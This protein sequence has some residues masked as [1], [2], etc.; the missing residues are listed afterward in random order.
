MSSKLI[1][2][3]VLCVL[4][5]FVVFWSFDMQK[6]DPFNLNGNQSA[7]DNTSRWVTYRNEELGF[8]VRHPEELIVE[9]QYTNTVNGFATTTL[10]VPKESNDIK[11]KWHITKY[12]EKG[13]AREFAEKGRD[14]I[15]DIGEEEVYLEDK[16]IKFS[17]A[18]VLHIKTTLPEYGEVEFATAYIENN[19]YVWAMSYENIDKE[20]EVYYAI[21]DSFKF[22]K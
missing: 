22:L 2:G 3:I 18:T 4:L 5:I 15:V 16:K 9:E 17:R 11:T 6:E 7:Y 12:A 10:F 8:E 19:G 13:S 21:L 14:R 20:D 1:K